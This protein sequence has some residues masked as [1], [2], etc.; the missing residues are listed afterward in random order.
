MVAGHMN[1]SLQA[2]R[3]LLVGDS[4]HSDFVDAV[5]W[6]QNNYRVDN[7]AD[8]DAAV[9]S[10]AS[11]ERPPLAIVIACSHPGRYSPEQVE[12][13][14]SVSPLT[15]IVALL[16][17]WC[18][19]EGRS[20]QPWPGVRRHYWH[21]WSARFPREFARI[22]SSGTSAWEMPRTAT[23]AEQLLWSSDL[24]LPS[25][26]GLVAVS[27]AQLERFEALADACSLAQ[28]AAVW[29]AP[30]HPPRVHRPVA[31]IWDGVSC[32]DAEAERLRQVVLD[33]RPAPVLALLDFV[34]KNDH[35]QARAAGA[36]EVLA[37]PFLLTDLLEI[38]VRFSGQPI[39]G[40]V[41]A[42]SPK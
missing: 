4:R 41:V 38:L 32:R 16:G 3:V 23:D 39:S 5:V 17:S 24:P 1:Q 37:K 29:I 34:R 6:L 40:P 21:Q 33:W 25:G 22:V 35:R 12:S 15:P 9:K 28:L 8:I 26:G 36:Q 13:L 14:H 19:G 31:V 42:H 7:A 27:C 18:E 30:R 2:L 11:E 10:L 20:G